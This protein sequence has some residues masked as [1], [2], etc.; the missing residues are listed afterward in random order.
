[1]ADAPVDFSSLDDGSAIV[2]ID[3]S[4]PGISADSTDPFAVA[5]DPG[6]FGTVGPEPMVSDGVATADTLSATDGISTSANTDTNWADGASAVGLSGDNPT[7][8]DSDGNVLNATQDENGF[9]HLSDGTIV[10]PLTGNRFSPD[11]SSTPV[12]PA[13]ASAGSGGSG[14][15]APVGGSRSVGGGGNAASSAASNAAISK[16]LGSLGASIAALFGKPQNP[17]AAQLAKNR[18]TIAGQPSNL[19]ATGS[20]IFVIGALALIFLL[21]KGK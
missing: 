19:N 4:L 7:F 8:W 11:G 14:G 17:T 1:M 6:L 15:L 9:W 5:P 21:L 18:A 12:D 20:S 10:D 16:A 13:K 3:P 2:P